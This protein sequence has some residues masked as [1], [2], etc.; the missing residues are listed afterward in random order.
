MQSSNW[1]A[2]S[3]SVSSHSWSASIYTTKSTLFAAK[4]SNYTLRQSD[5]FH[6]ERQKQ[7]QISVTTRVQSSGMKM[8]R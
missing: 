7:S 4:P 5:R 8:P 2:S 1:L 3:T 6:M